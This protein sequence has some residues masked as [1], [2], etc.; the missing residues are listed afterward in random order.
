M[1]QTVAYVRVSSAD[2]NPERQLDSVRKFQP[3]KVFEEKL[4]GKDTNR[5]ELQKMLEYVREGD[6]VLV[7]SLDRLARSL[8]DLRTIIETLNDKGVSVKFITNGLE[9]TAGKEA[10]AMSVLMLNMLGA[11]AEFE[12]TLIKERQREGIEKA[13][14]RGVYKGRTADMRKRAEIR[15]LVEQG[16]SVRKVAEKLGCAAATVQKV[17][18]EMKEE[19]ENQ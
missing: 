12:R 13:K 19:Q 7:H 10:D 5:P 14:E 6:L 3:K 16:F 11:F 18:N 1:S 9:F 2:Q 15:A 17:R 4:S 8:P